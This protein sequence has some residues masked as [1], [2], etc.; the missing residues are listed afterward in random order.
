MNKCGEVIKT[1]ESIVVEQFQLLEAP[2]SD[3]VFLTPA[4]SVDVLV[5]F[6]I[7][8]YRH[9]PSEVNFMS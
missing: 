6:I 2:T 9:N 1:F 5:T 4:K 3:I 8:A 7:T